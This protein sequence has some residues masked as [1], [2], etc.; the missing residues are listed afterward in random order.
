MTAK[1]ETQEPVKKY[2]IYC[3]KEIHGRDG[4]IY[5]DVNCK[6]NFHARILA[7]KRARE[8]KV[9]PKALAQLKKNYRI[10][11]SYQIDERDQYISNEEL[12]EHGFNR[13]FC[14]GAYFTTY[15]RYHTLNKVCFDYRWREA[16]NGITVCHDPSAQSR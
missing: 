12:K 14:T 5:C 13:L 15:N 9:F 7:E 6:N 11:A 16:N 8:N 3:E 2:C 1:P 4:K 10:L